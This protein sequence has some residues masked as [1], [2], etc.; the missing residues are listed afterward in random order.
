MA[1]TSSISVAITSKKAVS[2]T[3]SSYDDDDGYYNDETNDNESN[4][5]DYWRR[6]RRSINTYEDFVG[7][8]PIPDYTMLGTEKKTEPEDH[9]K[10]DPNLYEQGRKSYLEQYF[11]R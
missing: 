7:M 11:S 6:H 3:S 9:F 4:N 8:G 5:S 1:S 10:P 2:S